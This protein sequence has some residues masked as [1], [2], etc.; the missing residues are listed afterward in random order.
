MSLTFY[1]A[2]Q[3]TASVTQ[4]CLEELGVPHEVVQVDIRAKERPALL[5]VNPNNKVPVIVHDG[6]P[7]FESAAITIY[8]GE[9]FGT[10]KGLWP[11]AGPKRGEA[12]K[13]VVWA[14]VTFGDA[15]Y[16]VGRNSGNWTPADQQNAKACE[17]AKKETGELLALLDKH[18][19]GKQFLVDGYTLADAHVSS[20][21]SWPRHHMGIDFAPYKNVLVWMDRCDARPAAK[22]VNGN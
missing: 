21:L 15:V 12:M 10:A 1:F 9:T 2:P 22:K 6:S 18:L 3:S 4:L 13:W 17:Q 19:A 8:L 7:I 14:N 11:A 20:F 5:A 16:R